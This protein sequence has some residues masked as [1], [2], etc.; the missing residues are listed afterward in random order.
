[1]GGSGADRSDPAWRQVYRS[2]DHGFAKKQ[3][4]DR[5]VMGRFP[6]EIQDF[7]DLFV[8]LQEERHRADYDPAYRCERSDVMNSAAAAELLIRALAAAPI[9]DRRALAVW[10]LLRDRRS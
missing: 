3:F 10:V 6:R 4:R 7:A 8:E 2:L 1:M 5:Q 9:K